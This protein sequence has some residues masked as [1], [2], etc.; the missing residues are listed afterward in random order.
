MPTEIKMAVMAIQ[1]HILVY[2]EHWCAL[3]RFVHA[4][5]RTVEEICGDCIKAQLMALV[6]DNFVHC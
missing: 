6:I 1:P 4:L 3:P 5:M 2:K